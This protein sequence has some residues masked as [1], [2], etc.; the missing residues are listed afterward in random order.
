MLLWAQHR[1]HKWSHFCEPKFPKCPS[2]SRDR[3]SPDASWSSEHCSCHPRPAIAVAHMAGRPRSSSPPR[4]GPAVA[5]A[6]KGAAPARVPQTPTQLQLSPQRALS[7]H[8][9]RVGLQA[10]LVAP[11]FCSCPRDLALFT[12]CAGD[13][14]LLE[15]Q[16]AI[17]TTVFLT[18]KGSFQAFSL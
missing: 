1:L 3:C 17:V 4:P 6:P 7:H 13:R 11:V 18:Q 14:I 5:V 15:I 10:F 12:V 16:R 2:V 9:H 8:H